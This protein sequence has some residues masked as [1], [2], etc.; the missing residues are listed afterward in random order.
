MHGQL[1]S[2]ARH[3]RSLVGLTALAL[4]CGTAGV[5]AETVAPAGLPN[6]LTLDDALGLIA[7]DHPDLAL[8]RARLDAAQAGVTQ[9]ESLSGTRAFVDLTQQWVRPTDGADPTVPPE[10][11]SVN[12]SRARLIVSK[13]LYDFGRSR[14][15]E[16]SARLDVAGR[17]QAYL[18]ARARRH[19]E[20]MA[21]FFDVI[22]ADLRYAVDNED[23]A[24]TY[25]RFDR[26]RERHR[27]GQISD[28][29]LLE[30]EN[31]YRETLIQR[32]QSQKR[33]A[34]ARAQ[35]ALA[36]NRP[37]V[38]PRDLARPALPSLKRELPDYNVL[39]ER[40]R[41]SSPLLVAARRDV[42]AARATLTAERARRRP[43]LSAEGEAA[44][45]E[46]ELRSRDELRAT[47][48]L[49]VPLYQ[50]GEDSAA[51]AAALA[52][53]DEREARLKQLEFDL[54]QTVFD[55]VQEL[56]ILQIERDAAGQRLNYRSLYLDRSRGLYELEVRTDL[57]DAMTR[58][59][60]AQWLAARADFRAALAWARIDA[61]T[62]QLLDPP[63]KEP[64]P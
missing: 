9:A 21:R 24:Q 25:V 18:D 34:A 4:L 3:L 11:D 19:I 57:G 40:M 44:Y 35:L 29:D 36:L 10:G 16:E 8:E 6:P 1:C 37:G 56:E 14:A 51:I 46:R 48:N 41:D 58:L 45:Y 55:L 12:D 13:R 28:V 59:S 54:S 15:L 61:L 27:L 5:R 23:M 47:L 49:R 31:R 2:A 7:E 53:V 22:L 62:G 38:L 32:T 39:L 60:E 33:Q 17:E 30:M 52:R 42:E 26:S 20:V 63:A 64:E 50:G 43:V